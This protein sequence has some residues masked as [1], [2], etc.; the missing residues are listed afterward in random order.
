VGLFFWGYRRK[1]LSDRATLERWRRE[2]ALE[3]AQQQ[4]LS[5][6]ATALSNAARERVH[7][8]VGTPPQRLAAIARSQPGVERDIPRVE[9][10]GHWHTL[11]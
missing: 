11:H 2:E 6:Q 9:H 10:D 8:V 3:D 5:H 1:K 4:A 7:I